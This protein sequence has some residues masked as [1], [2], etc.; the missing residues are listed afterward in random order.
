MQKS[1][2]LLACA[3]CARCAAR[4]FHES[5]ASDHA[6]ELLVCMAQSVLLWDQSCDSWSM[7]RSPLVAIPELSLFQEC[8][9]RGLGC[10]SFRSLLHLESH[11]PTSPDAALSPPRADILRVSC[12]P[13][14]HGM[15]KP[16]CKRIASNHAHAERW[17]GKCEGGNPPPPRGESRQPGMSAHVKCGTTNAQVRALPAAACMLARAQTKMPIHTPYT[18]TVGTF[19]LPRRILQ[20]PAE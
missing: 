7:A 10:V 17:E 9:E 20:D 8:F 6:A 12:A 14:W 3:P 1:S 15:A 18:T 5:C 11:L 2:S 19:L 16:T 4:R 13:A